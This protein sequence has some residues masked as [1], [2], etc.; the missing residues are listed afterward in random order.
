MAKPDIKAIT[1]LIDEI[2]KKHGKGTIFT[3]GSKYETAE[4][5]RVKTGFEDLDWAI[6]GG[7]PEGRIIEVY[8]AYSAG[9]TSFAMFLASLYPLVLWLEHEGTFDF[10][11]A[12]L[13][14]LRKNQLIFQRPDYGEQSLGLMKKF[15]KTGIP[16]IVVDSIP[17]MTPKS[18]LEQKND[19]KNSSV[20]KIPGMLSR[21]LPIIQNIIGKTGTTIV[22]INQVRDQ[23]G[24]LF[25]DP[26][27]TPGGHALRHSDSLKIKIGRK[28]WIK[29][30]DK[31]VVGQI[32]KGKIV[33]SKVCPP[34]REFEMPLIFTKG[35]V[36]FD[37]LK[38]EIKE[39]YKIAKAEKGVKE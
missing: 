2:N 16:L 10:Q 25:G 17:C 6:G 38:E 11:R 22:F 35:F 29:A 18:E 14:G 32:I 33:K 7:I 23:F 36:Q 34:Y 5:P 31:Y 26:H 15:A 13:F 39:A 19:D 1:L 24:V 21:K 28:E 30:K 4:I 9:K 27:T 37:N 20:G 3:L 8:G 12:K